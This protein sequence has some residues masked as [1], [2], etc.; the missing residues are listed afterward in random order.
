MDSSIPA[1]IGHRALRCKK[2]CGNRPALVKARIKEQEPPAT[3]HSHAAVAFHADE[4]GDCLSP[5]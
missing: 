2:F 5:L 4:C 3:G 1:S